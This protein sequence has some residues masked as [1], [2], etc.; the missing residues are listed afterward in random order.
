M[1]GDRIAEKRKQKK[2]TQEEVA[3]K[4][5]IP[6][7]TYSNYELNNREPDVETL[8][9]LSELFD[10]SVDWLTGN[11]KNNNVVIDYE[12]DGIIEKVVDEFGKLTSEDQEHFL[13][14]LERMPKK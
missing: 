1:L 8:N 4:L 12:R 10:C 5:G 11:K 14:L 9:M 7:S 13:R 6:R 2:M 3:N